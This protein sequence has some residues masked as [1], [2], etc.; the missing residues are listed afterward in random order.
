KPFPRFVHRRQNV[1]CGA[2][3]LHLRIAVADLCE[4]LAEI[5]NRRIVRIEQPALRKERVHEGVMNRTFNRLAELRSRHEKR[6]DVDAAR[7]QRH[8]GGVELPVV[9]SYKYQINVRL[10]PYRVVGEASAE[11]RGNDGTITLDLLD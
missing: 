11:N 10:R 7:V 9:D 6:M 1:N 4:S 3:K 8:I 5:R 2:E